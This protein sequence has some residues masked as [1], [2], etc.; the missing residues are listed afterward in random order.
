MTCIGMD[1]QMRAVVVETVQKPTILAQ[2]LLAHI[3]NE[4]LQ[5]DGLATVRQP[6][7]YAQKGG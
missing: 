3:L 5:P 1:E 4:F 6:D 7:A 2:S